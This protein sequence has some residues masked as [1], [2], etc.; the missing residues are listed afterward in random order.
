MASSRQDWEKRISDLINEAKKHQEAYSEQVG[1][2][3]LQIHPSVYSPKYFPETLWYGQNLPSIVKGGSFLE[4]GVGSGLISLHLA[5]SGSKVVGADINPFA[6][7]TTQQNFSRNQQE[8]TFIVSDI[9]DKI[10]GRFDFIFWNHPWQIDASVPDELKT[11]K[12]FDLGYQLL[13]RFVAESAN[14]LTENGKVLLGTSSF[15]DLEAIR[16]IVG[17]GNES[18]EI[19]RT[20]LGHLGR[21]V[22]EEYYIVQIQ[23]S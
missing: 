10:D 5:A 15:A 6:V 20:G 2:F 18:L 8:G 22:T 17:K 12:T 14:Y 1:Y 13:Q 19:V 16:S 7:E 3:Q 23:Q 9:F 4:I 21:G 11:E